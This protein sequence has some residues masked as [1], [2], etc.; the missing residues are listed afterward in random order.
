MS[1]WAERADYTLLVFLLMVAFGCA[2]KDPQRRQVVD[3]WQGQY[4]HV[5]GKYDLRIDKE[6][7]DLISVEIFRSHA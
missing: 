7:E 1:E 6:A 2:G 5:S 4:R 3:S